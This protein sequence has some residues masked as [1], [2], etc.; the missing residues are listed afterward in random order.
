[1]PDLYVVLLIFTAGLVYAW[2][3]MFL[4]V[5]VDSIFQDSVSDLC[6]ESVSGSLVVICTWP[7]SLPIATVRRR[8]VRHVWR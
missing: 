5:L 3:G 6:G 8:L 4:C 2:G 1:M 7:L